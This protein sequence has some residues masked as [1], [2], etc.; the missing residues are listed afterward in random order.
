LNFTDGDTFFLSSNIR[1]TTPGA[2]GNWQDKAFKVGPGALAEIKTWLEIH[3]EEMYDIYFCPLPFKD[4]IKRKKD[5]VKSSRLLWSD[6]DNIT[7]EQIEKLRP[8]LLWE[9]SPGSFQG[10]WILDQ[11]MSPEGAEHL[12]H[13]LTYYIGGD[14]SGWDLTQVLRVPGTINHKYAALPRV[15]AF[16]PGPE[17]KRVDIEERLK[18]IHIE[19]KKADLQGKLVDITGWERLDPSGVLKKYANLMS[20]NLKQL[21]AI[22]RELATFG[23]RSDNLWKIYCGC[24]VTCMS[25]AE[26]YSLVKHSNWNKWG[27]GDF[28]HQDLT[29]FYEKT[30]STIFKVE[31]ENYDYTPIEKEPSLIREKHY[32][33]VAPNDDPCEEVV[34]IPAEKK[35]TKQSKPTP[36]GQ[37]D[38]SPDFIDVTSDDFTE[39]IPDIY[40]QSLKLNMGYP[41]DHYITKYITHAKKLSD[42]YPE[43]HHGAV[44]ALLSIAIGRK[45]AIVFGSGAVFP[46]TWCFLVGNSTIS[47][48]STA[49]GHAKDLATELFGMVALPQSFSPE[50]FIEILA[51]TPQGWLIKDEVAS[52]LAAMKK[53]YMGEI[54]DIFCEVYDN[55]GFM[56][57]LRSSTKKNATEFNVIDPYVVQLVATTPGSIAENSQTLDLTSGWLLRFM[58]YYPTYQKEWKPLA[59]ITKEQSSELVA[60]KNELKDIGQLFWGLNTPLIFTFSPEAQKY[61]E[62]WQQHEE[63]SMSRRNDEVE[64]GAY[65]R[66]SVYAVKLAMIYVVGAGGFLTRAQGAIARKEK[67]QI[68]L[69]EIT[70]ACQEIEHYFMPTVKQVYELIALADGR[71]NQKRIIHLINSHDGYMFRSDLIRKLRCKIRDFN[72]D[73]AA[74]FESGEIIEKQTMRKGGKMETTYIKAKESSE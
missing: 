30:G 29:R 60:L 43:Y 36:V 61:F 41:A 55:K 40:K 3:P 2:P 67:I 35:E 7:P 44:V 52:L 65:G 25:P 6:L 18:E 26:M 74:L 34:E 14:P 27:T 62:N 12:N 28:L 33:D 66:L 39:G 57:K 53:N 17:Y 11:T 73:M 42:S 8:S 9:S 13:K 50:S 10:L 45:A 68:G 56:R 69:Q 48:K 19:A 46:N 64:S 1:D 24:A 71:N 22:K 21:I 15:S 37:L 32:L 51:N 58:F 16:T 63:I 4:T 70:W 31:V 47:R 23:K 54:R 72:D 49:V 59:E 20:L 38:V 5:K